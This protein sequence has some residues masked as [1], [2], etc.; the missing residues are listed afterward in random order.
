MSRG[1][2]HQ[3][4]TSTHSPPVSYLGDMRAVEPRPASPHTGKGATRETRDRNSANIVM[5]ADGTKA[6]SG[7]ACTCSETTQRSQGGQVRRK[8]GKGSNKRVAKTREAN[9]NMNLPAN[10]GNKQQEE[11]D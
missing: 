2:Q 8:T 7:R 11:T 1:E 6:T 5:A 4:H 3:Q 10:N 9:G